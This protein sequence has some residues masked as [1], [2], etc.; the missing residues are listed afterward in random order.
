MRTDFR[1]DTLLYDGA[2]FEVM[3]FKRR[4]GQLTASREGHEAF[5][6]S[7]HKIKL[8]RCSSPTK[9]STL[10]CP[11]RVPK[12][13]DGHHGTL[14]GKILN[15]E[16]YTFADFLRTYGIGRSTAYRAVQGGTLRLTKVGR[17]SRV[18]R[19]DAIAWA[20]SLPTIGGGASA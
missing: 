19:A 9:H 20:A 11:R 17:A 1:C 3:I 16:Y 2:Q 10:V 4:E 14:K 8:F 7:V 15:I 6:H 18:A 13:P 12:G 5:S